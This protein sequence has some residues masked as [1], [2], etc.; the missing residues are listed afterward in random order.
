MAVLGM[1]SLG[2]LAGC[3]DMLIPPLQEGAEGTGWA[4][5]RIGPQ[6][7]GA[8]TLMPADTGAVSYALTFTP[9]SG[10]GAEKTI[11]L[12]GNTVAVNLAP[13]TWNLL[14]MGSCSGIPALEGS[15][16]GIS[17]QSGET[18]EI[19]P[20]ELKM[21][22]SNPGNGTLHY[23][24]T[25]PDAV[26]DGTLLVFRWVDGSFDLEYPEAEVD[27]L[28]SPTPGAGTKT[29]SGDLPLPGGYYRLG[30]VLQTEDKALV[31][32][33][34]AHIYPGQIT[35]MGP[36]YT[37]DLDD[38]AANGSGGGHEDGE[39]FPGEIT[40]SGI[41]PIY[42]GQY[43]TFR[44]S[45]N[46][47]PWGGMYLVGST[48][49]NT[50]EG[51][52]I[53]NGSVTIPV[54]LLEDVTSQSLRPYTG[55]DA[56][57][58]IYLIIQH[59]SSFA[60]EDVFDGD[61]QYTIDGVGF[62]SDGFASVIVGGSNGGSGDGGDEPGGESLQDA[63][64]KLT[65][66]G[67]NDFDGKYVYSAL[68]TTSEKALIGLNSAEITGNEAVI[69]M[70]PISGGYAEVPLYYTDPNGTTVADIYVPYD[71]SE[72]FQVV[73]VMIVDDADGRF[74]AA[75]AASYASNYAGMISSNSG[76]TSFTPSTSGGNIT[77]S[78]SD[79]K[80]MDEIMDA[81]MGGD[82]TVMQT[83]KYM[84]VLPQ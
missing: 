27:L 13:G 28:D 34:I 42:D 67:F 70:V 55:N 3:A 65:L 49:P 20:I 48:N 8:R 36:E 66:T 47:P 76:N 51:A 43:A 60:G 50:L 32:G 52:Q 7:E 83:V 69:S 40:F 26:R 15:A 30:I 23:S 81:M 77:I 18:T 2:I 31:R 24:V 61:S 71:G 17:I 29:K 59:G 44:S 21:V 46:T 82:S 45:G 6:V 64:G 75:D 63:R 4:L 35:A 39:D 22:Q 84:L 79:V 37:F 10:G 16:S 56:G 14:V 38:F 9:V 11:E 12:T 53:W 54:W 62:S 68:I 80:T 1:V 41:D 72:P 19:P 78:R 74:T 5:V 73:A 25:F 58:Q 57:I 33:D